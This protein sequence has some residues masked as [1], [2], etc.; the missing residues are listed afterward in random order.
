[1]SGANEPHAYGV[2]RSLFVW[3]TWT[4]MLL[5]ALAFIWKFGSNVPSWDGWDMVPTLTGHQPI[6]ATW[7]W[8]QHNEHRV[9]LPRLILLGMNRMIGID[10]RLGMYF[11]ALTMGALAFAMILVA[12][13]L[14]GK[15]SW[16]D[17]FFPLVLL[18][19]G[20]AANFLWGWQVQFFTSTVLA[21]S[22]LLIIVQRGRQFRLVP[23]VM[24][25]ICLFLLPLCGANGLA[26]VPSLALWL[27]YSAVVHS[28][29]GKLQAKR[30]SLLIGGLTSAALLLVALYFVGYENV[31]YHPS[32]ALGMGALR[33]GS[34]FVT[35]GFG[36]PARAL[37]PLSGVGVLCLLLLSL[38]VLIIVTRNQPQERHRALGLFFFLGSMASLALGIGLSR[39][40]FE[41]RYVTLAVPVLCCLYFIWSIYGPPKISSSLRAGLFTVAC[42]ALWPNMQSG[43][44]YGL[45][46]RHHLGSFERDMKAGIPSY[47]LINRYAP[48]LHVHQDILIDY[49]PMLREAGV[50]Q[51]RF[52]RAN[53]PFREV[54]VRLV[55]I[56]L[57]QVRWEAGTAYGTGNYPYLVFAVPENRYVYGVRLK[58]SSWN[59][60][61]NLPYVSIYWKRPDQTEFTKDQF[62]KYSPTGDRANWERGTWLRLNDSETTVTV[63]ISE[64]IDQL[65]I[66]PDLRPGVFKISEITLMVPFNE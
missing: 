15:T 6:T 47:L 57:N 50:G 37:W 13:S 24:T 31:P 38:G 2:G 10:F 56:G 3:G 61:C 40:G 63:W 34:Q 21:G 51:F 25:G 17:A 59:E 66:H 19:W 5:A 4:V 64:T 29:S 27:G 28:R 39:N 14:R 12:R 16:S 41:I 30:N 60:E 22:V 54:P 52:L 9:P 58:Y 53:P 48:Y 62:W 45:D 35:L 23:L 42:I 32:G 44:D 55:P 36:P 43:I 26:L 49:M 20:H 8:S 1:M 11:G 33:S 7:L 18:N 46:L 65:R